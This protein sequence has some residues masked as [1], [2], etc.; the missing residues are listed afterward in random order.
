MLIVLIVLGLLWTS[1][2]FVKKKYFVNSRLFVKI[3]L[4]LAGIQSTS[5]EDVHL[6]YKNIRH[7]DEDNRSCQVSKVADV[8]SLSV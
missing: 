1:Q 4:V 6:M 3:R 2:W 5:C 7:Y 8:S